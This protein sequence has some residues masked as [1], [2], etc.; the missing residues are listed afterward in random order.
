MV[1]PMG[2]KIS[3]AEAITP[4]VSSGNYYIA[5]DLDEE[6]DWHTTTP[7]T[8]RERIIAQHKSFPY[9]KH[10]DMVDEDSQGTIR[11]I[12][13]ITGETPAEERRFLRYTKWYPDMWE[14]FEQM[15]SVSQQKFVQTYGAP[16]EWMQR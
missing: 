8:A 1:N 9:G 2:G 11:L 16:E 7:M 5:R 6:V 12:K 3:R 13:L 14:D 10:D 4:F 15:D